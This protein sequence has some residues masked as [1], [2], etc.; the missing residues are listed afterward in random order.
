MVDSVQTDI[1]ERK[2]DFFFHILVYRK[3]EKRL[4]WGEM[5]NNK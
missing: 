5:M 2:K 4:F 3:G 1:Q